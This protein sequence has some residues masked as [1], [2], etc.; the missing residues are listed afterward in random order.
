MNKYIHNL[1]DEDGNEHT[2]HSAKASI[3]WKAFKQRLGQTNHTS[4]LL[5][6]PSFSR[7]IDGLEE[8]ENPFTKQDIDEV[9]KHLP[10]DKAPVLMDLMVHSSKHAGPLSNMTSMRF[11][12]NSMKALS[13][14]LAST[15][16]SLH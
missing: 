11:A 4:N 12:H 9:V 15:M 7:R 5:N 3:L 6:L 10:T 13:I 14:S 1:S 16:V 8:L 2:E